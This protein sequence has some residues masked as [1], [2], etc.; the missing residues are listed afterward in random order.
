LASAT[1][2]GHA[3]THDRTP[4]QWYC[5]LV[6]ATLLLVGILGFIV[7]STFDTGS[8]ID[9]DSL[10]GFEVNGWHNIVHLLSG[11]VLLACANTAPTAKTAAIGFGVV[12]G[13]VTL[14]G[15]I[16]GETVLGLI[17][18]NP[19]DNVLHLALS[20]VGIAAGLSSRTFRRDQPIPGRRGRTTGTDADPGGHP[21]A[22]TRR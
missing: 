1:A 20:A 15:L 14:I 9:G 10:I 18:V 19:A 17:P 11:V 4:A 7:D 8:S 5:L 21:T 13:I 2:R 22:G 6:G 12:Y 16:D 3:E